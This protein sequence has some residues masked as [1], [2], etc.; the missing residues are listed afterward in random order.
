MVSCFSPSDDYLLRQSKND[1]QNVHSPV[2][3]GSKL[4]FSLTSVST[5]FYAQLE[6]MERAEEEVFT[7]ATF[8]SNI[9]YGVQERERG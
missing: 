4:L 2:K 6:L 3:S 8:M 5:Q 9:V 1:V 7:V